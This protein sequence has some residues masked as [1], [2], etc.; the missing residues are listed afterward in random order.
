MLC[1][2]RYDLVSTVSIIVNIAVVQGQEFCLRVDN[3]HCF[4]FY[5]YLPGFFAK[6][7]HDTPSLP[8][9]V[10]I[11]VHSGAEKMITACRLAHKYI[12]SPL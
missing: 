2:V 8:A 7:L 5:V 10:I 12:Y 1:S 11:Y 6:Q 9:S 3:S 4:V